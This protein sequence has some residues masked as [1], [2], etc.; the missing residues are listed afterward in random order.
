MGALFP[1]VIAFIRFPTLTPRSL[2]DIENNKLVSP[3]GARI[4][5]R[6]RSLV[7]RTAEDIKVCSNVCD[8]YMKKRPLAKVLLSS[9]WD[10]KLLEFVQLFATRCQEFKFELTMHTG[11][12]IDK[13]SAKLEAI[14]E[15][16]RAL[17]EQFGYPIP[18]S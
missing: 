5:D 1:Y 6:L 15:A 17:N 14:G 3:G 12:G 4:E 9:I 8:A 13:D 11:Q 7:D 2:K 10:A 16:T 18:L